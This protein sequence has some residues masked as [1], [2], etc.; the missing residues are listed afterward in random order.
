MSFFWTRNCSPEP[1][2]VLPGFLTGKT[3]NTTRTIAIKIFILNWVLRLKD[4]SFT[5][6]E[7]FESWNQN[8]RYTVKLMRA[9]LPANASNFTRGVPVKRPHMQFTCAT[10]R[11]PV[12][13]GKIIR[14]YA[15]SISR[16]LHANCLPPHVNLVEH[17]GFL[18]GNFTCGIH[19]K[20]P[21]TSMPKRPFL[22]VEM[23]AICKHK[24]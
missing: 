16:I 19:A 22:Q 24:H 6:F 13:R 15:A 5:Q 18:R 3:R 17:N 9:K 4:P 11:L 2:P 23:H 7:N 8:P 14:V 10:C 21:A 12:N 1:L 20:L